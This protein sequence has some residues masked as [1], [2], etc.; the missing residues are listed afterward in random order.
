VARMIGLDAKDKDEP[1]NKVEVSYYFYHIREIDLDNLIIGMKSTMDGII[2][3][4]IMLDDKPSLMEYGKIKFYKLK[5]CTGCNKETS[6]MGDTHKNPK[7]CLKKRKEIKTIV[8]LKEI[9]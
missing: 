3:S 1:I 4:G 7:Y 2:D 6:Y 5:M 9:I 8:E